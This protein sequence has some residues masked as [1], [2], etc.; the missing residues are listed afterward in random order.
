MGEIKDGEGPSSSEMRQ[1]LGS[2]RALSPLPQ[3]W[4][5]IHGETRGDFGGQNKG[6]QIPQ[7]LLVRNDLILLWLVLCL[8]R[9][10]PAWLECLTGNGIHQNLVTFVYWF[11]WSHLSGRRC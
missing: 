1:S 5:T 8:D 11:Y 3:A 6:Q 10:G 4:S 2:F 7:N 9:R